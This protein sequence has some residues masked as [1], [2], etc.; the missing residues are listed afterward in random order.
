VRGFWG[1]F[2]N[3]RFDVA[4]LACD[5]VATFFRPGR[6]ADRALASLGALLLFTPPIYVLL[7]GDEKFG[8]AWAFGLSLL[9]FAV[10]VE[11]PGRPWRRGIVNGGPDARDFNR[12]LFV[13]LTAMAVIGP[14]V[15]LG[16]DFASPVAVGIFW[17]LVLIGMQDLLRTLIAIYLVLTEGHPVYVR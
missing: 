5:C 4:A 16:A 12:R 3:Y 2:L 13:Q 7:L 11:L 17:G 14:F 8:N 15:L 10:I 1:P 6:T 9:F